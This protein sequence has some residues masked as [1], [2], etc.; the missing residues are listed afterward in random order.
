MHL[1]PVR[2]VLQKRWSLM[3]VVSQKRWS[4]RRG[5]PVYYRGTS[6]SG[7]SQIRA[8]YNKPLYKGHNLRPP[9]ISPYSA[10]T[11]LTYQRGQPPDKGQGHERRSQYVHIQVC[12]YTCTYVHMYVCTHICTYTCTY[13]H[14]YVCTHTCIYVG[15]HESRD[16]FP[17][18]LVIFI[19]L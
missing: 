16:I 3:R 9:I 6:N 19:T 12:T 11:S 7:L 15:S 18:L 14:M 5:T 10:C 1:F 2:L 13:V 4:L 17:H 8:Q